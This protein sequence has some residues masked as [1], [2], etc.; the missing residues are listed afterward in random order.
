MSLAA[1]IR[2]NIADIVGIW[3]SGDESDSESLAVTYQTLREGIK[4]LSAVADEIEAKLV[5]DAPIKIEGLGL[6]EAKAAAKRHEWD[7]DRLLSVVI[8]TAVRDRDVDP[9]TGEIVPVP[10]AIERLFRK[11]A[12]VDYWRMTALEE[13][14]ID[15]RQYRSTEWGRRRV[16]FTP[17]AELLSE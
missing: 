17:E 9:Q 8:A 16:K 14:G 2:D 7:H 5:A 6:F 11:V 15:G 13:T 12:H 10:T 3:M 1:T 4:E